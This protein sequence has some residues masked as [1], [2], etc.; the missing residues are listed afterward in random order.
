[1]AYKQVVRQKELM[2]QQLTQEAQAKL[3]EKLAQLP[4]ER[5]VQQLA[6]VK[7]CIALNQDDFL[8]VSKRLLIDPK[9]HY[10]V[11]ALLLEEVASLQGAGT[12]KILY[13]NQ[14][15]R[16]VSLNKIRSI[17]ESPLFERLQTI[18]EVKLRHKDPIL[19]MNLLEEMRLSYALLYPFNQEY[20][21]DPQAWVDALIYQYNPEYVSCQNNL[22]NILQLVAIQEELKHDLNQFQ[23]I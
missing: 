3:K 14:N 22:Q 18:L 17:P 21:T 4:S 12:V 19:Q 20:I 13:R 11:K 16:Q 5:P 6:A 15:M 8:E 9:V 7:D 23:P 2:H 10:L 1:M